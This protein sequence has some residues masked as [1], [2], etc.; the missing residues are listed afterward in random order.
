MFPVEYP[1]PAMRN[2]FLIFYFINRK[3]AMCNFFYQ[4]NRMKY[5]RKP[6]NRQRAKILGIYLTIKSETTYVIYHINIT[7]V[8]SMFRA[9]IILYFI[10]SGIC[11]FREATHKFDGQN[12]MCVGSW[13]HTFCCFFCLNS[14]IFQNKLMQH[15]ILI[16]LKACYNP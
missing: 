13:K 11:V 10:L 12:A 16:C 2:A 15:N 3:R 14:V 5:I 1:K 8:F 4:Q 9:K 7:D 6:Y